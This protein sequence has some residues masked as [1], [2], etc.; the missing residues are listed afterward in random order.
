[1][2]ASVAINQRKTVTLS[3]TEDAVEKADKRASEEGRSR[4]NYLAWLIE[5][6]VKRQTEAQPDQDPA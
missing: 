4:S 1:M 5:Q 3:L 6:D 2:S